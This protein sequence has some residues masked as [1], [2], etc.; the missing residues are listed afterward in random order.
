MVLNSSIDLIV[1]LNR[2][3]IRKTLQP[4][5]QDFSL[6]NSLIVRESPGDEFEFSKL[7]RKNFKSS[8]LAI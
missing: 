7:H 4:P 6:K 2:D 8:D 5:P 1:S 3:V